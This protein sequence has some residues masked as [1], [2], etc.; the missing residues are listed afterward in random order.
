MVTIEQRTNPQ[1]VINA[2]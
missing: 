1:S 2:I